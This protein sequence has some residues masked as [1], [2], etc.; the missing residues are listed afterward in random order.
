MIEKTLPCDT[1]I[2]PAGD[3]DERATPPMAT[4]AEA[5]QAG[6]LE[7]QRKER[8]RIQSIEAQSLPG[9]EALINTLKW[10]GISAGGDA[11]MRILA[12]EKVQREHMAAVLKQEAPLPLSPL[13]DESPLASMPLE[14][15]CKAEWDRSSAIR[16]EFHSLEGYTA[17][18]KVE[19]RGGIIHYPSTKAW[20][21]DSEGAHR[22]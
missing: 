18:R 16:E 13:V 12:V 11:A 1:P 6:F 15:R 14:A 17:Y 2:L 20:D 7:G 3:E 5:F 9:H 8:E 4:V 22:M 10:D 21:R 19:A